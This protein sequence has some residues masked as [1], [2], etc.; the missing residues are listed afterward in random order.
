MQS[1]G[2][3][4]FGNGGLDVENL[5]LTAGQIYP[6]SGAVATI[7][8][9]I[10][11][12]YD[13]DARLV[14]RRNDDQTPAVPAS[15]FGDLTLVAANIDQGAFFARRWAASGSTMMLRGSSSAAEA[16]P[17]RAQPA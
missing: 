6:L 17:P 14:I 13:P 16:S 11:A 2:D 4:R 7:L 9:G 1:S 8:V 5:A 12:A 3:I 15:V 10:S